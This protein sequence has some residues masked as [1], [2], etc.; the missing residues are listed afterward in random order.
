MTNPHPSTP[1]WLTH[2]EALLAGTVQDGGVGAQLTVTSPDGTLIYRQPLARH[3]R[4]DDGVIWLRQIIGDGPE[5]DINACRRR[6]LPTPHAHRVSDT[7]EFA[8]PEGTAT[9]APADPDQH[10][11]LSNWDTFI[12]TELTDHQQAELDLL[13]E[14]S[15]WA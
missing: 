11:A 5:F 2:L 10:Q 6:N 15:W 12:A 13:S 3:A 4:L 14:D 7:I 8:I 1:E 9:I